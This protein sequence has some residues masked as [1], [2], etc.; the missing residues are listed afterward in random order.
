MSSENR[1]QQFAENI[2]GV[3]IAVRK[4]EQV[5][6][7]CDRQT[8]M[9]LVYALSEAIERRGAEFTISIMP[10][11]PADNATTT[12]DVIAKSAEAADVII[13][14]NRYNSCSLFDGRVNRLIAKKKIRDVTL[15]CRD[16]EVFLRG[17]ALADYEQILQDGIKLQA[18]WEKETEFHMTSELGTDLRGKMGLRPILL[19]CG[20]ARNPGESMAFSDG[21][22]SCTPDD[23]TVSGVVVSNGPIYGQPDHS[24][25]V[26]I[27]IENS[28]VTGITCEDETVEQN[29]NNMLR[30]IENYGWL[31]EIAIGLNPCSLKNGEF[32]EE[33]K[34]R[35]NLHIALGDN[36]YYGGTNACA[37]HI[38][39]VIKGANMWLGEHQMVKNGEYLL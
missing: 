29:M 30:D 10:V 37:V 2:V 9:D 39:C 25:P 15:S 3:N 13:S 27:T 20:I 4:G 34:S 33:K 6:M 38:D 19:G 26:R 11:R 7:V 23:G 24:A 28:R 14:L 5:L 1:F 17:G 22:V 35:G 32:P 18:I 31:A 36:L 21:E 12:T 16:P 8:N